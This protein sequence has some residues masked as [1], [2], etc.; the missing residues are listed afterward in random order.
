MVRA[1]GTSQEGVPLT[2]K[3]ERMK[4]R[5]RVLVLGVL[6][7][8]VTTLLVGQTIKT[9]GDVEAQGFKGDGSELSN[10]DSDLL[11]GMDSTAFAAGE[12]THT[13]DQ[14]VGTVKNFYLTAL[15]YMGTQALTACDSGFHMASKWEL[16][17]LSRLTYAK[18]ESGALGDDHD[19]GSGGQPVTDV[20]GWIR[21]GYKS[22]GGSNAGQANCDIWSNTA[23]QGTMAYID[24]LKFPLEWSQSTAGCVSTVIRVWCI[25]D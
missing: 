20:G 10:V 13:V 17:D 4:K 15:T 12:H 9:D 23:A 24:G 5:G 14:L 19:L 25:E 2:A 1:G 3:G 18:D 7:V 22:P 16:Q 8:L 11:D 6:G 21:T